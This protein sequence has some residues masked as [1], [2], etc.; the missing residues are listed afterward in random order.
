VARPTDP[1]ADA[2][3]DPAVDIRPLAELRHLVPTLAAWFEAEWPAYYGPDGRGD[4]RADLLAYAD[5]GGAPFGLVALRSLEPCGFV[6]LKR[7]AFPSH[8]HLSP[9][10]G[11]AC[12]PPSLRR[13]GIGRALL[14]ALEQH[15]QAFG[16]ARIHCAT[17]TAESLLQRCGWSLLARVAHE[18]QTVGIYERALAEALS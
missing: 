14:Q 5:T 6:A 17:A 9:W 11:A 15:A 8:P 2:R 3:A 16:Y 10:V 1:P 13:R 7:E 4:A 12:V 18:G